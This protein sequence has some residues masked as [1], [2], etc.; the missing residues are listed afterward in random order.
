MALA[1]VAP[2]PAHAQPDGGQGGPTYQRKGSYAGH[3]QDHRGDWRR[4]EPR[5]FSSQVSAGSFQRPYPYHLDYYRMK[6]GGSYAP[7]FG[8]LYGPPNYNYYGAPYYGDYSPYYGYNGYPPGGDGYGYEGYGG[9][10]RPG[11]GAGP[12][13]GGPAYGPWAGPGAELVAPPVA[14]EAVEE[15]MPAN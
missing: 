4:R 10:G 14:G 6:W 9:Y 2:L 15:S 5:Q 13:R 8:N 12:A 3:G 7:Y 1:L 11:Y